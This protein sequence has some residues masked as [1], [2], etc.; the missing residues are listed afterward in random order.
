MDLRMAPGGGGVHHSTPGQRRTLVDGRSM[1]EELMVLPVLGDSSA[2]RVEGKRRGGER[3]DP[4]RG[5]GPLLFPRIQNESVK[6]PL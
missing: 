1:D 4:S 6:T 2:I 5:S 3:E